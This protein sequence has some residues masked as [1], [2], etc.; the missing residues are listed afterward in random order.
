MTVFLFACSGDAQVPLFHLTPP[1]PPLP[2]IE[3]TLAEV[4]DVL[5]E[6]NLVLEDNPTFCKTFYGV[7]DH[8]TV[9][10]SICRKYDL[11]QRR[12]TLAHEILHVIYWRRG[13]D[14]GGPFEA[15]INAKAEEIFQTLY[16]N[17]KLP[18]APVTA[19]TTK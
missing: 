15:S 13:F 14:T 4:I 8:D 12:K 9:T 19:D 5:A 1:P 2:E 6:Y 18:D 3:F 10:I 7:T 16:G 11:T 17:L